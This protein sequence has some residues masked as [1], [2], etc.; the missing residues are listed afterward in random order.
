MQGPTPLLLG[1]VALQQLPER[2][3][4]S[5]LLALLVGQSGG[6]VFVIGVIVYRVYGA[7]VSVWL[8]SYG[9]IPAILSLVMRNSGLRE[10]RF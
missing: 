7:L 1:A 5:L 9:H 6:V 8:R 4:R 2:Q 10:S 3:H